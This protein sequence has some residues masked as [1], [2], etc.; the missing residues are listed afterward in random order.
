[1]S[2]LSSESQEQL[3]ALKEPKWILVP[4]AA[5]FSTL[6]ADGPTHGWLE[7]GDLGG[8][9]ARCRLQEPS[10]LSQGHDTGSVCGLLAPRSPCRE[11]LPLHL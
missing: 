8:H 2:C 11:K 7:S 5:S 1:M 9:S 3:Q 6:A 10:R 4:T